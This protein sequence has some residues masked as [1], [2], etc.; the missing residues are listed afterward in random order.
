[1]TTNA[2]TGKI[3]M[4]FSFQKQK[5]LDKIMISLKKNMFILADF[6]K[7]NKNKT[8]L[9]LERITKELCAFKPSPTK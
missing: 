6:K 7:A 5:K 1:M 3:P 2:E 8:L 4:I 9:L